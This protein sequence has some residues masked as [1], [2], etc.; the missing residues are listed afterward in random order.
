[1]KRTIPQRWDNEGGHV[2][3]H[4]EYRC[5]WCGALDT[6]Y[7]AGPPWGWIAKKDLPVRH[8]KLDKQHAPVKHYCSGRCAMH[9]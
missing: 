4:D 6:S 1:M 9:K 7:E 8:S 3:E 2:P 5:D